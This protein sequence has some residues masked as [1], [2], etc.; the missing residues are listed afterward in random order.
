MTVLLI[1]ERYRLID[2]ERLERKRGVHRAVR[3]PLAVLD[4]AGHGSQAQG[5]KG[6]WP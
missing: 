3:V 5:T 1:A 6:K 2:L 4:N